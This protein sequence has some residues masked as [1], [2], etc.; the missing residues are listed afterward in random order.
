MFLRLNNLTCK[1]WVFVK[2]IYIAKQFLPHNLY[3]L[4]LQLISSISKNPIMKKI[5]NLCPPSNIPQV[6]TICY[7]IKNWLTR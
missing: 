3:I 5:Y 2:C 7:N 6:A 4:F 1:Q